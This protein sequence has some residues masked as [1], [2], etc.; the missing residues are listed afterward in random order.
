MERLGGFHIAENVM[1]CIGYSMKEGEIK[2]VLF[3]IARRYYY[4]MVTCPTLVSEAMVGLAWDAFE[5]WLLAEGHHEIL[6]FG[7]RLDDLHEALRNKH[8]EA[9]LASSVCIMSTL[10]EI[11]PEWREFFA[12]LGKTAKYWLMYLEMVSILRGYIKA[13]REGDWQERTLASSKHATIHRGCKAYRLHAA[14]A[15][16]PEGCETTL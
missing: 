10:Q 13:E 11:C 15:S 9:A 1:E 7:E 6:E 5:E 8:A 12:S 3:V 16:V 14:L 4:K 2:D